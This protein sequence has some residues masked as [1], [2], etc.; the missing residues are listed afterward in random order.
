MLEGLPSKAMGFKPLFLTQSSMILAEKIPLNNWG[1]SIRSYSS[2]PL[3]LWML[4]MAKRHC[5]F[6]SSHPGF[7]LEQN[8]VVKSR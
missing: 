8:L 1:L 3:G 4:A 6:A 2:L 7:N 5:T